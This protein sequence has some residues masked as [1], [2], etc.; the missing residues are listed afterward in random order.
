MNV[1]EDKQ[2]EVEPQLMQPRVQVDVI[3]EDD[4]PAAFR[5]LREHLV[6]TPRMVPAQYLYDD[7]GSNLFEEITAQPEYYQTRTER[8]LLSQIAA[9]VIKRSGAE[10]LVELGSGASTKTRVLL[11]AMQRA[12]QLKCYVPFDVSEGIVR[13]VASEL[14]QE[15]EGLTIH[16]IIGDFVKQL[17]RIPRNGRRLILFLGWTIGNFTDR[18]A[19][20]FLRGVH[21]LLRPGEHLLLGTD[22]IKDKARLHAAYNDSRH[23]TARFNRNILQV[24]NTQAAGNFEPQAFEHEAIYNVEKHRIEMWLRATRPQEVHLQKLALTMFLQEG[25]RILTEIS[26]KFDRDLIEDV[27]SH[28]GLRLEAMYTD[29][30]ADFA[31]NLI[32]RPEK[33]A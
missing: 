8:A 24:L 23:I 18:D 16:G 31:L 20:R 1:G 14:T 28:S 12:G 3:L 7:H 13:R 32:Q 5:L 4:H 27:L 9:E 17:H 30:Q 25:S 26:V 19:R 6:S 33:P 15:Y 29:A 2:T 21:D 11:D 22:L 10:E